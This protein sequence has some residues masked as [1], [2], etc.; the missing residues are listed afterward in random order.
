[1]AE[2]SGYGWVT[3]DAFQAKVEDLA[4]EMGVAALLLVPGVYELVAE[5]V[6]NDVLAS[7]DEELEER[8]DPLVREQLVAVLEGVGI[9]CYDHEADDVLCEAVRANLGDGTLTLDDLP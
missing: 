5:H 2:R 4:E 7:L 8:L 9:Q 3:D 1:M 6:N